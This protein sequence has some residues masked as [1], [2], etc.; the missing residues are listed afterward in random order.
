MALIVGL[1]FWIRP[2]IAP[3]PTGGRF[4]STVFVYLL[5]VCW[6]FILSWLVLARSSK[7]SAGKFLLWCTLFTGSSL[8]SA[9]A[10]SGTFAGLLSNSPWLWS[11]GHAFFLFLI[12]A[13]FGEHE[14]NGHAAK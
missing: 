4:G 11:L 8:L 7:T 10:Y 5:L 9:A 2:G 14:T 1:G 3:T 6:P 13:F 12:A